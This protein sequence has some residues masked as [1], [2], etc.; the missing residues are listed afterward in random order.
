MA[1]LYLISDFFFVLLYY[2]FGYRKKVIFKN[3]SLA[4]PEKSSAEKER[5]AKKFYR[6][7]T[8][9]IVESIK[10]FTISEK[11]ILK[12]YTYKNPELINKYA[13]EGKS[14]ALVGAHL[15]NWEWSCS[16]P[17]VTNI[18]CFGAYRRLNNKYFEKA[19]LNTRERF[20]FIAYKTSNTVKELK[21]N[22]E[23]NIQ[24]L[25][26][27]LSDQSPE[28][29]KTYYWNSFFDVKVPMHTG[30]E[31]LAKKFNFVVI[32]YAVK[33]VKRGHFEVEYQLITET[34]KQYKDYEITDLYTKI[35][36]ENI[37]KQPEYYLWSHNRFKH[38]DRF[39]EWQER[40]ETKPQTK[41]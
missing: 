10:A 31:M 14:I 26:L 33:K 8:D 30:A 7:F 27:L 16:M 38:K 17:L 22:Y 13:K 41:S 32:N 4:F 24:G 19:I 18:K 9:I 20:G 1:V 40:Y 12:R 2:V 5:I 35:T 37:R 15:A 39:K 36:E 3:L 11:E 23:N 28:L 34:P 29:R 6:H 21:N 25:Y